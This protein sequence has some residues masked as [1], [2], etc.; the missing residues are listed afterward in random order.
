MRISMA[1][2]MAIEMPAHSNDHSLPSNPAVF[3]WTVDM[4]FLRFHRSHI[5]LPTPNSSF[6]DYQYSVIFADESPQP[7]REC[8]L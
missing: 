1:Q 7:N 5:S 4:K 6:H 8:R 2:F 3:K